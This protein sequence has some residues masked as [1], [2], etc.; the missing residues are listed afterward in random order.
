L[1]RKIGKGRFIKVWRRRIIDGKTFSHS[2]ECENVVNI[3]EQPCASHKFYLVGK[4]L[5]SGNSKFTTPC[6]FKYQKE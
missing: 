3:R 2:A 5:H 6:Y 1:K 4:L